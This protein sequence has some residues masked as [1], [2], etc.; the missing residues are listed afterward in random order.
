MLDTLPPDHPRPDLTNLTLYH[1]GSSPERPFGYEGQIAIRELLLITPGL[2]KIIQEK[3]RSIAVQDIEEA[4]QR[5]GGMLTMLQEGVLKA[6]AGETTV[7][8]I[9]RVIG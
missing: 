1:P 5:E 8:E 2:Q 9:Y 3:G 4:A 6:I 7:E